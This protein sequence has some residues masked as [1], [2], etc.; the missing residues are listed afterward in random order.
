MNTAKEHRPFALED[1]LGEDFYL[2]AFQGH[3]EISRPFSFQMSLMSRRQDVLSHKPEEVI[4]QPANMRMFVGESGERFI[5]GYVNRFTREFEGNS[6]VTYRAEIV[7]WLW[8]LTQTSDCRIFEDMTIPEIIEEVFNSDPISSIAKFELQL[9]KDYPKLEYCVQFRETDFNFVTRLMEQ[10][11]IFYIFD[12]SGDG[13]NSDKMILCDDPMAYFEV[14]ESPCTHRTSTSVSYSGVDEITEWEHRYEFIGGK[15]AH[16]DHTFKD[17]Y[18]NFESNSETKVDN[19]LKSTFKK[20]ELYDGVSEFVDSKSAPQGSKQGKDLSKIRMGEEEHPF[21]RTYGAGLLRSF[22]AGGKFQLESRRSKADD[23]KTFAIL[24]IQHSGNNPGF[25]TGADEGSR[26]S[27]TFTCIPDDTTYNPPRTT[28]KPTVAGIQSATV[29]GPPGEEIHTDEHARIKVLFH[30]AR[31]ENKD[32]KKPDTEI[33]CW[34]RVAQASAGKKWGFLS[35]PRIGQE[36]IVDFLDGD[37]DRPLVVGSVYNSVQ[38]T[39]Y[40]L[41]DEKARTYFKTNSTPG[42]DGFNELFFDDKAD[43]ERIFLHAQKDLDVRVLNDSRNRTFGNR[44]QIIGWEKDGKKGGSQWEMIYQDKEI[45]VKRHQVEHIEGNE[46]IMIGNGEAEDGGNLN[47]V[48][49]KSL[50]VL[51]GKD[52]SELT[53]KGDSKTKIEGSNHITVDK[54]WMQKSNTLHTTVAGD[55]NTVAK[56]ISTEAKMDMH[57]KAGKLMALDG[58]M[59]ICLN[60]GMKLCLEAGVDISLKVGGNFININPGGVFIQ[61]TLVN[62]NSGGSAQSGSG[63]SVT[64]PTAPDPPAKEVPEAEPREPDMAHDEKTGFKSAPE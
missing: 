57:T 56:A 55:F 23:G 35:I 61:G 11:G 45:N 37:P 40:K 47:I 25:T 6:P 14:Q 33:S 20:Y 8:F 51:I 52:G 30:W 12:H 1:Q 49:E 54:D 43:K 39:A 10:A 21:S 44:S 28:P 50:G 19:P 60:A 46:T 48:I 64:N 36:V 59:E 3:E 26:Y 5:K 42:G 34:C 32:R 24:S 38:E 7:P 27:N 16:A 53:N 15:W 13:S 31:P 17:P 2:L 41:P 63:V 29:V 9:Q 22:A 18:Q 62:I 4:Y 58:G